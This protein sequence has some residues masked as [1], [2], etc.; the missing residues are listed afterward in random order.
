MIEWLYNRFRARY[1]I[2]M[3][4]ITRLIGSI[5][6]ALVIYYVLLTTRMSD[7]MRAHFV[8]AGM[9]LVPFAVLAT[10]PL[11]LWNTRSLRR[12]LWQLSRNAPVDPEDGRRA[13]DEAVRFPR[14]QNS[15]EAV[16]V[17]LCA[18][19]PMCIYLALRFQPGYLVHVQITIASG[20]AIAS[21]LLVTFFASERCGC[22]WWCASGSSA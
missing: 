6:G 9:I 16:L 5:G 7:E 19:V 11:A 20:L 21:V 15:G 4:L 10:V 14:R 2:V 18:V 22:G 1:I 12:V 8:G 13:A 3:M 17:P